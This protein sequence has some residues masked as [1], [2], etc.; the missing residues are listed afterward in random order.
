MASNLPDTIPADF[1]AALAHLDTK[2]RLG[3]DEMKLMVLLETSGEPLYQKL[4]S[5]APDG[6]A[7]D[8]LLKNGRE[9]TAH[10]HRLKRAI[11][12]STGEPFEVPSLDENPYAEPPPF[13]EL[14][15]ELLAGFEAG[16]KNGDAGYQRWA[17]HEPNAEVAELLRQN[18]REET[19]HGE[20]VARVAEILGR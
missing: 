19:L 12:I 7:T 2:D 16:E 6:E 4:A 15:P 9:E 1:M 11:E 20:R 8:L 18:G 17:D 14:T 13:A 5:L 3:V 10:A